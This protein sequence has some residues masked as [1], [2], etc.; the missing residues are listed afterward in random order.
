MARKT[1]VKI[2]EK[3]R[4]MVGIPHTGWL[5]AH[6]HQSI[7]GMFRSSK[8]ASL[9]AEEMIGGSYHH[10]ARNGLA[11][12]MLY[13]PENYTHL[14]FIDSDISF[15]YDCLDRLITHDL[16]IVGGLVFQKGAPFPA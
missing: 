4:V 14:L 9:I 1:K 15:E 5:A 16:D 8:G 10:T 2:V 6:T 11:W 12:N 13:S 3:P 7:L